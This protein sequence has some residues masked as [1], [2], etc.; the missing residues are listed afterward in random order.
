M[1]GEEKANKWRN[2]IDS[3]GADPEMTNF[4]EFADFTP[5]EM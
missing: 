2:V 4:V 3:F 1:G 5:H